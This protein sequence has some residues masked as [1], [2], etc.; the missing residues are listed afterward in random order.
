MGKFHS[1]FQQTLWQLQF[2]FTADEYWPLVTKYTQSTK[3]SLIRPDIEIETYWKK[4]TTYTIARCPLCGCK[5]VNHADIHSLYYW[6][7][8]SPETHLNVFPHPEN[9]VPCAHFVGVQ[10]FIN[11]NSN[12]PV[13]FNYADN[14]NGDVPVIT[15]ELVQHSPEA[16]AVIHS[17]PICRIENNRFVPKYSAYLI[18][19]YAESPS[20]ARKAVLKR[21]PPESGEYH[22]SPLFCVSGH[23]IQEPIIANLPYWVEQKKLYWLDLNATDLPLKSSSTSEFPYAGITGFGT[24]WIYRKTPKPR[25]WWQARQWSPNGEIRDWLGKRLV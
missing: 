25:W 6:R 17:L 12:L 13:E 22:G 4:M 18:T 11:L 2:T 3:V 20:A 1:S 7:N 23:Q 19:Y 10:R 15:P 24:P 5:Y 9:M 14:G 21:Y 16:S 8:T